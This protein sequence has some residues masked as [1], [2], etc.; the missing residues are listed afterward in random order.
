MADLPMAQIPDFQLHGPQNIPMPGGPFQQLAAGVQGGL[1]FGQKQQELEMLRQQQTISQVDTLLKSGMNYP[2]MLPVMWPG[3]ASRMNTLS[4]DYKLDPNKPPENLKNF[5]TQLSSISD[6]LQDKVYSPEQAHAGTLQLIKSSYPL[7]L[8]NDIGQTA[9]TGGP[10]ASPVMQAPQGQSMQAPPQNQGQPQPPSNPLSEFASIKAQY[11]KA[12]QLISQAPMEGPQSQEVLRKQLEQSSLGQMYKKSLDTLATSINSTFNAD[13]EMKRM[14]IQ[15]NLETTKHLTDS[16]ISQSADFSGLDHD[17][18]QVSTLLSSPL[19]QV[20]PSKLTGAQKQ[21]VLTQQ[22]NA[23]LKAVQLQIPESKRLPGFDPQMELQKGGSASSRLKAAWNQVTNDSV[24]T[25]DMLNGLRATTV[26]QYV[27]AEAQHSSS[28]ENMAEHA[29]AMGLDPAQ[30]I[31]NLRKSQGSINTPVNPR[32]PRVGDVIR[33][34][35]HSGVTGN[36]QY[37]KGD[38]RNDSNWALLDANAK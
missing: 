17:F 10:D 15:Q 38:P 18:G 33:M 16:F 32:A 21:A 29:R 27:D 14:K 6:G 28:E 36:F 23:I 9:G 13:Q 35:N 25:P 11:D 37:L 12:N 22:R 24:L 30:V 5:A 4:P 7:P 3:I 26:K 2:G 8:P 19:M 20:D 31:P 1:A 34:T